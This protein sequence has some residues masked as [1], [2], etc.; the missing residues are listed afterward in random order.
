MAS[1]LCSVPFQLIHWYDMHSYTIIP[2]L[3]DNSTFWGADIKFVTAQT[4]NV[5]QCMTS[6]DLNAIPNKAHAQK[7]HCYWNEYNIDMYIV[8]T[9]YKDK[10]VCPRDASR[11][12]INTLQ[13]SSDEQWASNHVANRIAQ[14][15]NVKSVALKC[16]RMWIWQHY[17]KHFD[18]LDFIQLIRMK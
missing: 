8:Y 15:R 7:P 16:Y 5:L 14:S 11:A 2:Y 10:H 17:N 3:Y 12:K 4:S 18:I 6:S 1:C 13:I 9:I